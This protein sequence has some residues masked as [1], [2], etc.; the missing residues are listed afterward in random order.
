M[1]SPNDIMDFCW[2]DRQLD[3]LRF[4][5]LEQDPDLDSKDIAT[6]KISE[7][8]EKLFKAYYLEEKRQIRARDTLDRARD[9]MGLVSRR[10]FQESLLNYAS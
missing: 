1:P 5:S 2:M 4:K 10:L 3:Y 9:L 6:Y 7:R 8:H